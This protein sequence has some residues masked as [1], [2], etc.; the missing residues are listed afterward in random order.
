MVALLG[1]RVRTPRRSHPLAVLLGFVVGLVATLAV[2]A[3][4]G[5]APAW[6]AHAVAAVAA[7]CLAAGYAGRAHLRIAA[8]RPAR[9][10]RP[11]VADLVRALAFLAL[12]AWQVG[13]ALR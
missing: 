12:A 1:R 7:L 8:D 4:F 3:S 13:A 10:T 9:L 6:P 5:L 11:I 2:L